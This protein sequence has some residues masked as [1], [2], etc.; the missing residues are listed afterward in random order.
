MVSNVLQELTYELRAGAI[1]R[2]TFVLRASTAGISAGAAAIM[3][4]SAVGQSATPA[5][6]PQPSL[7]VM[8]STSIRRE[9]YLKEVYTKFPM[10]PPAVPGG[11][12]VFAAEGDI[13]SVNPINRTSGLALFVTANVY[14][15]LA[16]QSIIDGTIIPDLADYW[17]IGSDGMTYRFHLN[18]NIRFHDGTPV[19]AHDVVFSFDAMLA[20][21]NLA[22]Y[23]G[24]VKGV[25]KSYKAIDDLT[26]ELVGLEPTATLLENSVALV[27]VMPRH[28]WESIPFAEWAAAPGS[29]G[30]DPS[31]VIGCGPFKFV[32]W[33]QGDHATIARN[34][35]YFLPEEAP[36]LDQISVRFVADPTAAVQA[37]ETG[38]SD[39]G[40]V[41]PGDYQTFKANHPDLQYS[42]YDSWSWLA[43]ITN[44]STESGGTFFTDRAVRQALLYGLDRDQIVDN[45]IGGMGVKAVGVQPPPSPAYDPASVRTTYD[46]DPEQ[47]KALLE[48]AG[49]VATEEN[50]IR[51]KDGVKFSVE[52][53]FDSSFGGSDSLVAFIQ[54]SWKAIGIEVNQTNLVYDDIQAGKFQI[55]IVGWGWNIPDQGALYRCDANP[56]GGFNLS[57]YCNEE[58]DRLNTEAIYELDE[59]KRID[60][61]VEQSNVVNDDAP[62]P[63]LYFNK[64][65]AIAQ[66][67]VRNFYAGPLGGVWSLS[68][69]WLADE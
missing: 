20:E 26:F 24:I 38:E 66:P 14:S 13:D 15:L 68:R 12:L 55:A 8:E 3:A 37:L 33:V 50:G 21:G 51:E 28:I 36:Y 25:V 43:L 29:T 44:A 18:P 6:S 34:D 54:E 10:Q 59:A 1:D 2:R 9:D 41:P 42:E 65:A 47:A 4:Q 27:P 7:V 5:A 19:T 45:L 46:Y 52:L 62:W 17:E 23:Q 16:N 35:D 48:E 53:N 30:A 60:L 39:F 57:R 69:I 11:H 64:L 22:P 40:S 58:Y 49:W 67:R 63:M 61:L 56:P 31:K 32:E